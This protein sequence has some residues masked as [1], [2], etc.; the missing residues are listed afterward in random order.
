MNLSHEIP[1]T[2]FHR[3]NGRQT[4][5]SAYVDAETF[6]A[7]EKVRADG[8]LRLTVELL[9]TGQISQCIEDRLGDFDCVVTAD[10]LEKTTEARKKMLLRFD[11]VKLAAWRKEMS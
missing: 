7:Y 6:A 3:P 11:L 4:Q 5:T 2:E 1:F 10:V 8:R 9:S